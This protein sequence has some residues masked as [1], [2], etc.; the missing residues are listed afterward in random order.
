MIE[1]VQRNDYRDLREQT[2][3]RM[4]GAQAQTKGLKKYVKDLDKLAGEKV[5]L[6]ADAFKAITKKKG[7][8]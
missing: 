3:S 4:M 6:D 7:G 5:A 1:S 2:I 8:I